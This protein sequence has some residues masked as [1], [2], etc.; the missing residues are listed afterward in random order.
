MSELNIVNTQNLST[1]TIAEID[2]QVDAFIAKHKENSV[3]I[4]RIVFDGTAALVA[5][6]NLAQNMGSH[7]KLKRFWRRFNGDN[8]RTAAQKMI[9]KLAEQNLLTVELIAA[10][11]NSLNAQIENVNDKIIGIKNTLVNFFK[12]VRADII[13]LS[14][15]LDKVE[16]N[17]NLLNWQNSIEYQ[18]YNGVEY[19]ELDDIT[20]IVCIVRDFLGITKGKWRTSD[21]LLL[22]TAMATI[23]INPKNKISYENFIRQLSANSELC[24]HLLGED[25]SFATEYE[26]IAFSLNKMNRLATEKLYRSF[27]EEV[28]LE[29]WHK[30]SRRR[31][32]LP[33]HRGF[34]RTRG[35]F[36]LVRR[37]KQL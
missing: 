24:R 32:H 26:A 9:Q 6:D 29:K 17:V 8:G 33:N 36:S 12:N 37:S 31:N 34:C 19:Q 23:G 27:N 25:F 15:R 22:K 2:A 13:N 7:G 28:F 30:Y 20:K 10:V 1:E 4:N 11:N 16:K 3:E 18:M 21:L 35:R 14:L 5:G